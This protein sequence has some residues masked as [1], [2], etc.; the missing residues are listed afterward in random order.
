MRREGSQAR[1]ER[2]GKMRTFCTTR[3]VPNAIMNEVLQWTVADQD[4]SSKFVGRAR[5]TMLPPSMRGPLLQLMYESLLDYFP[6]KKGG[7]TNP[8][9]NALL[10]KLNPLVLM[11][12]MGLI[13]P[14]AISTHLYVLQKGCLRIG[15]RVV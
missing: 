9:C 5:L 8:G 14:N 7:M 3:G 12:G 2:L 4:F 1:S 10:T 15:T 6:F 13:E 11:R